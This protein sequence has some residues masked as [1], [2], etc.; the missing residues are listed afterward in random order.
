MTIRPVICQSHDRLIDRISDSSLNDDFAF[1]Q[2]QQ[3][4]LNEKVVL[5]IIQT[6]IMTGYEN[7]PVGDNEGSTGAYE[8]IILFGDSITQMSFNQEDGFGFGAALQACK[9]PR[10][11]VKTETNLSSRSI[12]SKF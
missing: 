4:L 12:C 6:L 10:K 8:Q 11:F 2:Y 1:S 7:G 9:H 3:R 5:F